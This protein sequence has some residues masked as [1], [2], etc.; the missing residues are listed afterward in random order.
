M[1]QQIKDTENGT[2]IQNVAKILQIEAQSI[3]HILK[4]CICMQ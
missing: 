4:Q 2:K 3:Q 1:I